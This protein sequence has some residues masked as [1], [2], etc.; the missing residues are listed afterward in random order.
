[1]KML[2]LLELDAD[3]EDDAQ[4]QLDVFREAVLPN[5]YGLSISRATH[6][7]I[8]ESGVLDW[9]PRYGPVPEVFVKPWDFDGDEAQE[10]L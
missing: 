7:D 9:A 5:D 1:M 2:L 3:H 8:R 6:A 4:A 10:D